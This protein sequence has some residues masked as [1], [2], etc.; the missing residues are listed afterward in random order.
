MNAFNNEQK[1][2]Q[3]EVRRFAQ[4]ELA[5][6]VEEFDKAEKLPVEV[7]HSL[8]ELG[9]MGII[10]PEE[11]EGAGLDCTTLCIAAEELS[12]VW[13][14]IGLVMVVNNCL[15]GYPLLK[16]GTEEQRSTYLKK[17][18]KSVFGGYGLGSNI[19]LPEVG[20]EVDK[21]GGRYCLSGE[22]KFVLNG[23]EAE[24]FLFPVQKKKLLLFSKG[25]GIE[26]KHQYIL[27]MHG[28]GIVRAKFDRVEVPEK[29]CIDIDDTLFE[30]AH[31]GFSAIGLGIAQAALESAVK[32]SKERKQFG[33][34][35]CEFPMVQELLVDMKARVE[36]SRLL[37]YESAQRFD[38]GEDTSSLSRI[39]RLYVGET[40]VLCGLNAIQ[41]YGGYGYTK[42]YPVERYL[43]DAKTLQV[44]D[45]SPILLKGEIAKELLK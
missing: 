11:Y 14:S 31:I 44:L 10:L 5:P 26:L 2:I 4:S 39:T 18:T 6:I 16:Y 45:T 19:S 38:N 21:D 13:A 34:S 42:D 1:L 35:I 22:H 27:G 41:V 17:L 3:Q 30:L 29:D 12:K 24:L 32:Y 7:F 8:A 37:V 23:A 40:A 20:F 9:L 15:I 25:S 33:R 36:T 43:R 28:A